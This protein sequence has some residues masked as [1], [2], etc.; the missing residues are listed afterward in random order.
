MQSQLVRLILI[1]PR[2]VLSWLQRQ[3]M[4]AL[5]MRKQKS[6]LRPPK[7]VHCLVF[8]MDFCAVCDPLHSA[9]DL[10]MVAP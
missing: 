10:Y 7:G 3:G 6:V 5:G 8:Q 9:P 1:R 2:G 4:R